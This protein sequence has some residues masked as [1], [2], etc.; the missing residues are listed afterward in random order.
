M[1]TLS[2]IQPARVWVRKRALDRRLAEGADPAASPELALRAR[3]LT[4]RRFRANLARSI[5]NLLDTADRPPTG[6]GSSIP[7][8]RH[9]ILAERGLLL[10]LAADLESS[11]ELKPKG[12]ALVERL[13]T[14]GASPVY[15]SSA[16]GTLHDLLGQAR[17]AMHLA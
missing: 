10:G 12:I 13:I 16:E 3:Q 5:Y 8:Q 15:V 2:L 4:S 7:V 6:V 17:A 1:R 9:D 11:D 14:D